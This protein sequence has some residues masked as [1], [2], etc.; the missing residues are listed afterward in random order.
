MPTFTRTPTA[1]RT[2]TFT[3]TATSTFTSAPTRT[4]APPNTA[5]PL[6]CANYSDVYIT[7]FFYRAVDWLTCNNLISG[8]PDNTFRPYNPA[9]RAQI[10][11]IVVLGEGWTLLAPSEPVFSDVAPT[12]W[13]YEVVSTA[14]GK[15]IIGGYAD[16]T[17]RPNSNVTRGQLSKIITLARRWPLLD[18][19]EPHF[20]DVVRGSTFYSFIETAHYYGVVSGYGDGTFHASANATRGQLAKMLYV[21][22][23]QHSGP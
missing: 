1:T 17:F 19:V 23:T 18:P 15:G 6:P 22:L 11:K 13:F 21:A 8:Y 9:T 4:P 5:T 14:V 2:P 3:R 12:D 10:V 16:G 7:H 20:S